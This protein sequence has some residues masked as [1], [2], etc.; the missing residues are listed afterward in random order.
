[1]LL[2]TL[3][4]VLLSVLLLMLAPMH[5]S[6]T[7]P[8][9][10]EARPDFARRGYYAVVGFNVAT[11]NFRSVRTLNDEL[12]AGMGPHPAPTSTLVDREYNLSNF[13]GVNLALGWRLHPRFA[14]EGGFTWMGG[15]FYVDSI[16]GADP[17]EPISV[18][19]MR[20]DLSTWWLGADAKAFPFTGRVQP[21]A[22]LGLG[23]QRTTTVIRGGYTRGLTGGAWRF[24]G[25][26][27][28]YLTPKIAIEAAL[29]YQLAMG[30]TAGD[31]FTNLTFSILYRF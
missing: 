19:N 25:G 24:G 20:S 27:D 14:L 9:P 29:F 6:A 12:D 21:F 23:L 1:M 28:I 10:Q 22:L 8:E 17:S 5:C 31:D 7:T 11:P 4:S 18:S 15:E 16:D 3:L 13:A 26:I 30:P 2:S